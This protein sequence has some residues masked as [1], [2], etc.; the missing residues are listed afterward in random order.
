MKRT[1][2]HRS[3][4]FVFDFVMAVF[5]FFSIPHFLKK[6]KL[7]KDRKRLFR[8][9]F[10]RIDFIRPAGPLIWVHAVSVGEVAAIKKFVERLREDFCDT[11]I[12]VST[13]TPTGQSMAEAFREK[14]CHVIYFP[15]DFSWVV[16]RVLNQIKPNLVLLA[17]TEI[18]P[19]F[20][21]QAKE[22]GIPVGIINGRMSEKSVRGYRKVLGLIKPVLQS[23]DFVLAQTVADNQRYAMLG[24]ESDRIHVLGNMKFDQT[25]NFETDSGIRSQLGYSGSDLVLVAGSTH[26]GEEK[27]I[28]EAVK[29]LSAEFSN[30]KLIVAPRHPE[31]A[32]EVKEEAKRIG[33]PVGQVSVIDR[34]GV[35]KKIYPA[36]DVVVMGGS[37][38]R[39]GGQNPIEPAISERPI[40]SGPNVFNFRA[41]Y[42]IFVKE[43]A[44]QIVSESELAGRIRELLKDKSKRIEMG[45]NA[46]RVV[47][48]QQGAT[49]R[50]LDWVKSAVKSEVLVRA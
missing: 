1:R 3:L 24:V 5:G 41:V 9:R 4:T 13:V 35:L 50:Y 27:I 47:A 29:N 34:V 18:W 26:P 8:E 19:N 7:A 20:I 28:F 16:R 46:K 31:R 38:I 22:F 45:R 43:N 33:L 2:G 17:E 15:L 39:H 11:T 40:L 12:L 21:L 32:P 36:A 49:E 14:G 30:L 25:E 48:E 37:F 6:S 44:A 42:E 10:G 23:V